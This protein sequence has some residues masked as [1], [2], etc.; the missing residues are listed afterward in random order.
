[1]FVDMCFKMI[2]EVDVD[3][4]TRITMIPFDRFGGEG[5]KNVGI[6]KF[7]PFSKLFVKLETRIKNG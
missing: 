2:D 3:K 4:M 6:I 7:P 5:I 1:M